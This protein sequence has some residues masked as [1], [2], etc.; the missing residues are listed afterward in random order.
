MR[1]MFVGDLSSGEHFF[2]FGHGPRSLIDRGER[3]FDRVESL[4]RQADYV[5]GNLEGPTSDNGLRENDP[6]SWVFRASP[7]TIDQLVDAN[8]NILSVANNHS[9]Q[10]GPDAFDETVRLLRSSKIHVIGIENSDPLILRKDG[11]EVG[12]L[13]Y[14]CVPDNEYPGEEKYSP[15]NLEIC[16]QQTRDLSDQV[17]CVIVCLHWGEE[18]QGEP[19]KEQRSIARKLRSAGA[20]FI[21]GHHPHVMYEIEP[22]VCGLVAYSLGNFVFDLP[23]DKRMRMSGVLDLDLSEM[24]RSNSQR[25]YEASFWPVSIRKDGKPQL[26]S[27]N[28]QTISLLEP[29]VYGGYANQSLHCQGM[30]K[31]I[32]L[33]MNLARGRTLL[34]LKF[35]AWKLKCKL[36]AQ[37]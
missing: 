14:S 2:S 36:K 20:N 31:F 11:L 3:I 4:F 16:L 19:T 21:V 5:V 13:A 26:T 15:F 22:A 37:R 27:N 25:S 28:P 33:F 23:W 12:L 32:Y 35:L 24:S 29:K 1:L 30:R 9:M 10:H 7:F 34:K 8:I 6:L 17:D 18:G